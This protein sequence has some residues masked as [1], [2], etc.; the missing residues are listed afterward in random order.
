MPVICGGY[1]GG[2]DVGYENSENCYILKNGEWNQFTKMSA[3]R[4]W[5]ASVSLTKNGKN[6]LFVTGGFD[7]SKNIKTTEFIYSDGVVEVGTELPEA[8]RGHC[9]A[10]LDENRYLIMGGKTM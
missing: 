9:V 6:A 1:S 7:N 8:R 5:A 2:G 4:R 3:K 10:K